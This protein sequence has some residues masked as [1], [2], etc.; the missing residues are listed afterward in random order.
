DSIFAF[1]LELTTGRV[2]GFESYKIQ[3]AIEFKHDLE[4]TD[5]P[6]TDE[7][8]KALKR[9]V[10]SKPVYKVTPEQLDRARTYVNRQ[11]RFELATAAYG[12]QA[13]IQVFNEVDPQ[14]TRAIEE[15]P[16]AR[17]LASAARRAKARSE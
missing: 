16:R 17:E 12:S 2:P 15:M 13:A 14:V 5:Y 9:F 8:F 1:A 11:L 4:A 10:A 6:V 3:K 7:L